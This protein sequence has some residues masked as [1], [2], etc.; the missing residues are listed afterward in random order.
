M[1]KNMKL[2]A[3]LAFGFGFVLIVLAFVSGF[4]F[5]RF[6]MIN[7]LVHEIEGQDR[8]QAEI[9]QKVTD[10]MTWVSKVKDL[11]AD[12]QV[13]KLNVQTDDRKCSLGK[14]LY[15]NEAKQWASKDPELGRL[16]KE[17]EVPH[18]QLHASAIKIGNQYKWDKYIQSRKIQ[19]GNY[20]EWDRI[21]KEFNGV[22]ETVLD[23]D[24]NPAKA[25]AEQARDIKAMAKWDTIDT[26]MNE[27]VIEPFLLLRI[28]AE[29]LEI[30]ATDAQWSAYQNRLREL[31]GG[32]ASWAKLVEGNAHM[33]AAA[34]GIQRSIDSFEAEGNRYHEAMLAQ[35]E[36]SA[37]M[38]QAAKVFQDETMPAARETIAI[39]GKICDR[40]AGKVA[41]AT[42]QIN[43]G[44]SRTISLIWIVSLIAIIAG[45]STAFFITRSITKPINRVIDGLSDGSDQVAAASGQVSSASQ[46]LAE[47]AA[48]QASSIQETSSSLEEMAS[49]TKQNADNAAQADAL[50]KETNQIVGKA[51]DSMSGLTCSMEEISKASDETSKIIKTIDEIAFQTN[52]LALNAAVEAARA[53]EHGAG[54]AV[55]AEEVRNLAMRSAEAAKN[56]SDLIEGTIKSVKGGSGL[57][58]KTNEAFSGV[59][60]SV[61]KADELVAEI[62]AASNEQSQGIDQINKA[63]AEMDKVIQQ[64]AANAE[65]SASASEE[66]NAQAEQMKAFVGDLVT[67]V[68]GN[69]NGT[70]RRQPG[71]MK[72]TKTIGKKVLE[73]S[74]GKVKSKTVIPH[75]AK[76]VRPEEVIPMDD[77]DFKDF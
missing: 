40:L 59:A 66:M 16:F 39:L 75:S 12:E 18:H 35:R 4:G 55:V 70:S 17:V 68:G 34:S 5:M 43:D 65:E 76:D 48:E 37:S 38:K 13:T 57:V 73:A 54:F 7:R 46:S 77:E 25:R 71:V 67:L 72:K 45:I 41:V 1:F 29:A 58:D 52:L 61:S 30:R 9:L 3:K 62:A 8:L 27:S 20:Q 2:S 64:S 24:I 10:H 19:K 56:T 23:K 32:I 11:F 63:V 49:M 6:R 28:E 44:I 15:S 51:N 31:K 69:G 47:G 42:V 53:G 22:L 21:G 60:Q 26:E 36:A 74:V 50:M 33:R 14:W